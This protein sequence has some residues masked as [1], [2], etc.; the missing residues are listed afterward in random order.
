MS[1]THFFN[2]CLGNATTVMLLAV[3]FYQIFTTLPVTIIV[4]L[5]VVYTEDSTHSLVNTIVSQH[6]VQIDHNDL[7]PPSIAELRGLQIPS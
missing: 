5:Y 1:Q 2:Y 7:S 4:T 3:S 6:Q